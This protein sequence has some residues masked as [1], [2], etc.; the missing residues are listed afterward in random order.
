V[1][2]IDAAGEVSRPV[3]AFLK[4][5]RAAGLSVATQ[6]SYAMALLRWFRFCWAVDVAWDQATRVE[7]RDFCRGL[8]LCE[9]PKR[10]AGR[11]H[12]TLRRRIQ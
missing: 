11:P 1:R 7:A 6:R 12:G 10:T 4:D 5:L 8:A 9:K 2:L 3:A